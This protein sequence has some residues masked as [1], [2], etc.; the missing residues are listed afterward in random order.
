VFLKPVASS[1]NKLVRANVCYNLNMLKKTLVRNKVHSL[2]EI[3]ELVNTDIAV[4]VVVTLC[5]GRGEI[6][7]GKII[8][9]C[10]V[11]LHCPPNRLQAKHTGF[12]SLSIK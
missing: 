10:Y 9:A 3:G 5:T 1:T 6:R 12:V 2:R 11:Q 7:R 4:P 8:C